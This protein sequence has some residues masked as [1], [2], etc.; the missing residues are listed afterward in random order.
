[1]VYSGVPNSYQPVHYAQPN[2]QQPY[3]AVQSNF[4]TRSNTNV[5]WI[6]GG[7]PS[8]KAYPIEPNSNLIMI[9]MAEM[10]AYSKF[11]D[12]NGIQTPIEQYSITKVVGDDAYQQPTH[13]LNTADLATKDDIMSLSN[14]IRSIYQTISMRG[15][16]NAK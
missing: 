7:L 12:G 15:D 4:P 10:M 6:Q 2:Y 8:A 9:D 14:E 16:E 13:E 11:A 3:P 5:V 1:M